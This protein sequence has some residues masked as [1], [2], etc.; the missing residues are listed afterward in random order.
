MQM[1]M[2]SES[3]SKGISRMAAGLSA[4]LGPGGL[5]QAGVELE[6]LEEEVVQGGPVPQ[7]VAA[8]PGLAIG[9]AS[10]VGLLLLGASSRWRALKA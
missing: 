4:A 3:H 9:L 1:V 10:G 7:L 8:D 6:D 5:R 2:A